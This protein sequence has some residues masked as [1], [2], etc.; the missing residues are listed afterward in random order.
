MT[1]MSI[2]LKASIVLAVA[3]LAQG[4]FARRASAATRHLIWTLTIAGVLLLPAFSAVLP[5]WTAVTVPLPEAAAAMSERESTAIAPAIS[6]L[7]YSIPLVPAI[8]AAVETHTPAVAI[9]TSWQTIVL[10]LYAAGVFLLL[11]RLGLDRRVV[12]RLAR[13]ATPVSDPG[14]IRL[15][16]ECGE[17]MDVRR[18]VQ[19][20]RSADET[21]P[22]AFGTRRT[23]L[24]IPASA[25]TWPDDR[26]RAVLL[27]E[28]AHVAR[29]DCLT[30][31]LAAVACALYWVHPGVWWAARRLRV[32]REL[33][34]D[35]RVLAA[36]ADARD[37][38]GHLLEL[39]YT[40]RMNRAPDL[41]VA[42][43]GARQLEGRM[44]ALLDAT[45]NRATP[46]L[47]GRLLGLAVLAL[48]LVPIAA[49]TTAV[50]SS[51]DGN[52]SIQPIQT[53]ERDNGQATSAPSRDDASTA[54]VLPGTWD[55]R[56]TRNAGLVHLQLR[57]EDGYT[58]TTVEVE[59]LGGLA[60]G[61]LAG[62]GPVLFNIRRDAG[63]FTFDGV[64]RNG[65]GAG[66]FWFT[67]SAEFSAELAKRGLGRPT[68]AQ[69]RLLARGN[70]GFAVLDEFSAQKYARP[71]LAELVRLAEHGVTLS[72]LRDMD[73]V[74]YRLGRVERLIE[75]R[76]HDVTPQFIGG[77][78]AQG[79]TQLSVDD[80]LRARDHDVRP[81][82]VSGLRAAGYRS[83]DLDALVDLRS[84]DIQPEYINGLRAFGYESLDLQEVV[85]LRSHDVSLEYVRGMVAL[86]YERLS[87]DTLVRLRS[88]D[89]HPRF[90][91]ALQGLGYTRLNVDELVALR[92]HDVDPEEVRRANARAG[93]QLFVDRLTELASNDWR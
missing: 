27:H 22:M 3:A 32:E 34:C 2:L 87:T 18:P 60:P 76:Q 6:V 13:N 91:Q 25:D 17:L 67:P 33:A 16:R 65:V 66:T 8:D 59:S 31:I 28:L 35:D 83:L 24:L 29:Y 49:A 85:R 9:R 72:Y 55:L 1:L 4:L 7:T 30:Q 37:Y 88:H 23:A 58:G 62:T 61:Q 50:V 42:M 84:H 75:L 48:L 44:L 10:A 86:G 26:R 78:A 74:G 80:L 51:R 53:D 69:Q 77:L 90:V 47:R 71:T 82:Y 41:A 73:R 14:W 12:Q 68:A 52:E 11:A 79:L 43:A 54:G 56:P 40:L 20:L 89:I 57:E 5:S 21:M 63:T 45:R 19:L 46:A 39:A 92:S 81:E 70:V 36:G 64:T 15:L 93:R 38:A